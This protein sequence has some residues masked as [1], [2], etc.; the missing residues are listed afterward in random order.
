LRISCQTWVHSLVKKE[1]KLK[2]YLEKAEE[3]YWLIIFADSIEVNG[4]SFKRQFVKR[5]SNKG[6][7]RVFLFGLF[8]G[9]VWEYDNLTGDLTGDL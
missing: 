5:L 8:E 7:D 4:F 3:A 9:M 2:I 1:Q 6:F